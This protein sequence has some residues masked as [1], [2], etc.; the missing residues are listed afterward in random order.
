M[1]P[2]VYLA[3]ALLGGILGSAYFLTATA[4]DEMD[5][6]LLLTVRSVLGP[7]VIL[8]LAISLRAP[9]LPPLRKYF[10]LLLIVSGVN[11]IVPW[12]LI[13]WGQTHTDSGTAGVLASTSPVFTALLAAV[14]LPNEPL[15]IRIIVGLVIGLG[16]VA[17][18]AGLD[19]GNVGVTTLMGDLAVVAGALFWALGAILIRRLLEHYH[20]VAL[21]ATIGLISA[22]ILL[23]VAAITHEPSDLALSAHAWPALLTLG[24]FS[25]TGL[26]FPLYA[27]VI[28]HAGPVKSSLIF[29]VSPAV[30]VLLGW[31]LRD[32]ELTLYIIG[33]LLLIIV[34]LAWVND[35]IPLGRRRVAVPLTEIK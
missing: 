7:S 24:I 31:G 26:S 14:L 4:L 29:Y 19:V 35:L 3:L 33:G 16:G 32:E 21:V 28:R 11:F 10:W 23:P 22:V 25:G 27:W 5:P 13:N 8:P 34:S 30:A 20:E 9:L 17:L 12:L 18:I 6:L 1:K 15:R 2:L